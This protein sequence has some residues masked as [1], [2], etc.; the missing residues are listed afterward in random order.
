MP[1]A[2][3]V[4]KCIG[5]TIRRIAVRAA[6]AP[7][8]PATGC[9]EVVEELSYVVNAPELLFQTL[10]LV[11]QAQFELLEANFLDLFVFR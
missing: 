2:S 10:H 5:D 9:R 1:G 4:M 11:L 3:N 7:R 6:I 8:Q